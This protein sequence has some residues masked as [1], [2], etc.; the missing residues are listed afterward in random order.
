MRDLV[1]NPGT[2]IDHVDCGV[3]GNVT[4]ESNLANG[5]GFRYAGMRTD[6]VT[7]LYYDRARRLDPMGGRFVSVDQ[8]GFTAGDASGGGSEDLFLV[9]RVVRKTK[10]RGANGDSPDCVKIEECPR[11][12]PQTA[13]SLKNVHVGSP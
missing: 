12:P 9:S 5:D 13:S 6:A 7:G 4:N 1:D 2:L 3:F 10:S 11:R 8:T